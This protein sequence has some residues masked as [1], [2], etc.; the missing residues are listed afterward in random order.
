[1]GRGWCRITH[2]NDK[3]V[4]G[5]GVG[6]GAFHDFVL[7]S[8]WNEH[9][10]MPSSCMVQWLNEKDNGSD[11]NLKLSPKKIRQRIRSIGEESRREGNRRIIKSSHR[12]V[13]VPLRSGGSGLQRMA[14]AAAV[15][16]EEEE[17]ECTRCSGREKEE[18]KLM[19]RQKR[20]KMKRQALAAASEKE[21]GEENMDLLQRL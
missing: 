13:R 5:V 17:E 18:G 7:V 16:K 9:S 19:R 1:L 10:G 21:D 4:G 15:K 14:V 6:R 20:R 2:Q 3:T 8:R 12:Q 11:R